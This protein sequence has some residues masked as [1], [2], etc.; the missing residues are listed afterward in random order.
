MALPVFYK[1][2]VRSTYLSLA[3]LSVWLGLDA[4]LSSRVWADM[5]ISQSALTVEYCEFNQPHRFFHQPINTYSNLAYFFLGVL[6]LQIAREDA[7]HRGQPSL[8]RLGH[9]PGLSALMGA[10]FIYLSVGSAFFHASLTY[11][12]QRVDMNATYSVM[13]TL[14]GIALYHVAHRSAFTRAQKIGW[15]LALLLLIL[16]FLKLSLLVPSSKL[17]P[18]LILFLNGI[19]LVNYV[20]FRK[21]RSLGLLI[22]SFVLIVVAIKIRT[23]DVPESGL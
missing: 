22:L 14:A 7:T 16:S 1:L 6:V 21:E 20:Q 12:G 17:V 10:S 5:R 11:V 13:L 18:G 8:N 2:L 3:L 4:C 9:F 23:L 15:L 19:M